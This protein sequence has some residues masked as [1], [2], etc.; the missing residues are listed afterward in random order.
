MFQ[1]YKISDSAIELVYSSDGSDAWF[2]IDN[3]P[4]VRFKE[5]PFLLVKCLKK[6]EY[7]FAYKERCKYIQDYYDWFSD[8]YKPNTII[9]DTNQLKNIW[10]KDSPYYINIYAKN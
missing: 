8:N 4:C 10:L 1:C 2:E 6:N 3:S 7:I 5:L 9:M